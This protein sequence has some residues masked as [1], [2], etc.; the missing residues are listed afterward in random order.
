MMWMEERAGTRVN[1]E[2]TAEVL[3]VGSSAVATACPFCLSMFEDGIRAKDATER[4]H[5]LDV[6]E[7][8]ARAL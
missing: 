3:R 5:V 6:A 8:L 2:R 1:A 7:V 4:L